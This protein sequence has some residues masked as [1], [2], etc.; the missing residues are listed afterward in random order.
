MRSVFGRKV[1]DCTTQHSTQCRC[2]L[3]QNI[4][5]VNFMVWAQKQLNNY[6]KYR[7]FDSIEFYANDTHTHRD[8]Y[9]KQKWIIIK[10]H[11][12]WYKYS[13]RKLH[14]LILKFDFTVFTIKNY[15]PTKKWKFITLNRNKRSQFFV[16]IK[17]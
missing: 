9:K 10:F 3:I 4:S 16:C 2:M 8:P 5:N 15:K 12:I 17:K 11:H 1:L 7:I 13:M 6:R 14:K